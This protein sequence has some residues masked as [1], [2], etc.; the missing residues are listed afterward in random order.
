VADAAPPDEQDVLIQVNAVGAALA[1]LGYK[2]VSVPLDLDLAEAEKRLKSLCPWVVFNLVESIAADDRLAPLACG[3]LDH[4]G[5]PYTGTPTSGLALAS[6]KGLAKRWLR[7]HGVPT[8]AVPGDEES[9]G[10]WIVKSAWAHASFGLD[11]SSVIR[12]PTD[13]PEALARQRR[14]YGGEWFAEHYVE[15]R[16]F[17]VGLLAR[18]EAVQVLPIAEML[19]CDYPPDKPRI[20][21]Y[22]AKWEPGSFEFRNTIRCFEQRPEDYGLRAELERWAICCWTVFDLRGYARVD[23]RV[24][25][26]G[27]P[28]V[29]EVNANPCL[30]PDAGYA[31]ALAEAKIP[32]PQA[33]ARIIQD[34]RRE[35]ATGTGSVPLP[36]FA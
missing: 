26:N 17:N 30:S 9:C 25:H 22:S 7:Q 4:L 34:A 19:F 8:P 20:V 27:R 1:S 33:V 31:A 18:P 2:P 29:L 16:E 10:P 21:D 6:D 3:L 5:I 32:F 23:F 24:D 14:R 28:W 35:R 11:D 15:G 36:N 13:L 12:C